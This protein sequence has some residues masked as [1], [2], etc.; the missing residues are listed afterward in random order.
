MI[1]LDNAASSI[2]HPII[3]KKSNDILKYYANPFAAHQMGFEL[4]DILDETRTKISK[5]IGAKSSEIYFFSSATLANNTALLG[6]LKQNARAGDNIIMSI[7]EHNSIKKCIN[8]IKNMGIDVKLVK[9]RKTK[10]ISNDDII[11]LIDK[12]TRLIVIMAVNN[13][14]GTFWNASDLNT[15]VP[16]FSD[17]V[18]AFGKYNVD[19]K[20]NNLSIATFGFHKIGAFKG[21]G[22]LYIK[23]GIKIKPIINGGEQEGGLSP[24][25]HNMQAILSLNYIIDDVFNN[26]EIYRN[27]VLNYKNMLKNNIDV[28]FVNDKASD[29]IL[30]IYTKNIPAEVF[31]NQLSDSG[32]M[33]SSGS[34]CSSRSKKK[35]YYEFLNIDK[36][37]VNNVLRVSFSPFNTE[38][39][40]K[41]AIK[42][43]NNSYKFLKEIVGE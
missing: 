17:C 1:Y 36:N 14:T 38:D 20:K 15:S 10:G 40:I 19:V 21:L 28:E 22:A 3:L 42:I 2:V 11:E 31:K 43:I 18:Q 35:N 5:Y 30:N 26:M 39:E 12:K 24:G 8:D 29:Y 41:E 34:A 16:I 23:D 6:Y 7:Y 33:V 25:T 32:L 13:E 27:R 37:Y 9:P 4:K